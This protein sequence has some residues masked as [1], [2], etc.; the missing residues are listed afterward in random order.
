MIEAKLKD[1]AKD[2]RSW[3]LMQPFYAAAWRCFADLNDLSI[4]FGSSS[5]KFELPQP[6]SDQINLR[7]SLLRSCLVP[8]SK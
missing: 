5:S 4:V 3:A 7:L 6:F 2:E 8:S 1:L